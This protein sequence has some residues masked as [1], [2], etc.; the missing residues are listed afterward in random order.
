VGV[1]D[2]ISPG[3]L[4]L[5]FSHVVRK[6]IEEGRLGLQNLRVFDEGFQDRTF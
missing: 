6:K 5:E 1:E 4:D 3:V 2:E